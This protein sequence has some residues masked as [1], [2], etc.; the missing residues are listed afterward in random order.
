MQCKIVMKM[1]VYGS[2]SAMFIRDIA[3]S[4]NMFGSAV[5][6]AHFQLKQCARLYHYHMKFYNK[7]WEKYEQKY[8]VLSGLYEILGSF[9]AAFCASCAACLG[10]F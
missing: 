2:F 3:V 5:Y 9:R 4:K 7:K 8:L 1:L 10:L 6:Q